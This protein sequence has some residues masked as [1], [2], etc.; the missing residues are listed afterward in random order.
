MKT[1]KFAILLAWL[2]LAIF[3]KTGSLALPRAEFE[4]YYRQIT[5]RA[6]ASGLVSFAVD[7]T[8]SKTG[9]DA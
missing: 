1:V 9:N 2:P 6:P 5:G 4:K 7:S 3:A 8:V